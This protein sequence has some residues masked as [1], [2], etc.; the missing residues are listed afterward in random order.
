MVVQVML[1]EE[2][3][4]GHLFRSYGRYDAGSH[5]LLGSDVVEADYVVH[6]AL[7]VF[8]EDAVLFALVNHRRHF[9]PGN[10]VVGI[11]GRDQAG[12][13]FGNYY[14]RIS[15][16]YQDPYGSCGEPYQAPPVIRADALGDY[17]GEHQ[18]EHRDDCRCDSYRGASVHLADYSTDTRRSH[19]VGYGVEDQYRR[20]RAVDVALVFLQ[21]DRRL[22][23]FIFFHGQ[24]GNLGG[25]KRRLQ[26]R[27]KEG[28]SDG[29]GRNYDKGGNHQLQ[30]YKTIDIKKSAAPVKVALLK[31]CLW[32]IISLPRSLRLRHRRPGCCC[33]NCQRRERLRR[34]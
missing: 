18:D 21:A 15:D 33:L 28:Y 3:A 5:D 22:V 13:P 7:L 10:R 34:G 1:L 6:E 32:S 24:I 23:S 20:Q 4:D 27:A 12:D 26:Q 11:L 14:Q 30:R 17:F 25:Q 16:Y 8:L 19:S 2:L 9:L 29:Q 31:Y